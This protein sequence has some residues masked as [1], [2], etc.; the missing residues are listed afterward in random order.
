[1]KKLVYPL[2]LSED[3]IE[4]GYVAKFPDLDI[5]TDGNTVEEAYLRAK[6]Y[7]QAFVDLTLKYDNELEPA[8]PFNN[9]SVK[10]S[11]RIVLLSD[12]NAKKPETLSAKEK[13]YKDF[14]Q[15]YFTTED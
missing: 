10:N 8:T 12:A 15:K 2:V 13:C 7:L 14:V 3:T 9:V 6:D 11:K 4:G 1:M 5:I